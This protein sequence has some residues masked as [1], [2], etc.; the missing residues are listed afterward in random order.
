MKGKILLGI[1]WGSLVFILGLC[2]VVQGGASE[3]R[4]VFAGIDGDWPAF[5]E[6]VP[7]A[8]RAKGKDAPPP[9]PMIA[10]PDLTPFPLEIECFIRDGKF[11]YRAEGRSRGAIPQIRELRETLRQKIVLPTVTKSLKVVHLEAPEAVQLTLSRSGDDK[12]RPITRDFRLDRPAAGEWFVGLALKSPV[13]QGKVKVKFEVRGYD[14][15]VLR[16]FMKDFGARRIVWVGELPPEIERHLPKNVT[17][18]KGDPLKFWGKGKHDRVIV[19]TSYP[20][21]LIGAHV[22]GLDGIPHVVH[23]GDAGATAAKIRSLEPKEVILLRDPGSDAAKGLLESEAFENCGPVRF[24]VE[25]FPEAE[26]ELCRRRGLK[27]AVVAN[28]KDIAFPSHYSYPRSSIASPIYGIL[29]RSAVLF[30]SGGDIERALGS[31]K[32]QNIYYGVNGYFWGFQWEDVLKT[33][34][35]LMEGL[36]AVGLGAE[37]YIALLGGDHNIPCVFHLGS[38]WPKKTFPNMVWRETVC[39]ADAAIYGNTNEHFLVDAGVGRLMGNSDEITATMARMIFRKDLED[40]ET[41]KG[42]KALFVFGP[43]AKEKDDPEEETFEAYTL[44]R[45]KKSRDWK[46]VS[47]VGSTWG[48]DFLENIGGARLFFAN[49]FGY[50]NAAWGWSSYAH[51]G[52]K[53]PD[54]NYNTQYFPLLFDAAY[55]VATSNGCATCDDKN[56]DNLH[57]GGNSLPVGLLFFRNGAMG[58]FGMPHASRAEITSP[59]ESIARGLTLGEAIRKHKNDRLRCPKQGGQ[60][61][62]RQRWLKTI[63]DYDALHRTHPLLFAITKLDGLILL[64]DPQARPLRDFEIP[65]ALRSAPPFKPVGEA[66]RALGILW[67]CEWPDQKFKALLDSIQGTLD[68]YRK[69]LHCGTVAFE[70]DESARPA[71]EKVVS[72]RMGS[73]PLPQGLD[74]LC[75]QLGLVYEVDLEKGVVRFSKAGK[76]GTKEESF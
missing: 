17:L 46:S 63:P 68:K 26:K 16:K 52:Y 58:F 76:S 45:L 25:A 2:A 43:W 34:R 47:F 24:A 7:V 11:V 49:D 28:P 6:G 60:F 5:L 38:A 32:L 55:C 27:H 20:S 1:G 9:R 13:E 53:G 23:R 69:E 56:R 30:V 15:F 44:K 18:E 3:D 40:P 54:A 61:G 29:R 64:G 70:F 42:N 71:M 12:P 73:E 72:L 41:V 22:A 10:V 19:S 59:V 36:S 57:Y 8:L 75:G 33:R 62:G 65:E 37:S 39:Y 50:H 31:R 66:E 74:R 4:V 21:A 35:E 48:R 14:L 67:N 51:R